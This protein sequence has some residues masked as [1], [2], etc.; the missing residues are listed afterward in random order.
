MSNC[1]EDVT[2]EN[3]LSYPIGPIPTALFHD[4][5][6]MRKAT[7]SDL[8]HQLEEEASK[9]VTL[10][11]FDSACTVVIRDGMA[12]MQGTNVKQHK[13]FGDLAS[14]Y[15]KNL[16]KHFETASTVVDVY[17]RYDVKN[18]IKGCERDRRSKSHGSPKVFEVIEGR[19]IPD[20]KKFLS[21]SQNKQA[22]IYG[23]WVNI[24]VTYFQQTPFFRKDNLWF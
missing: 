7:K 6:T 5:S 16:V 22:L 1:R 24:F 10:S 23:L 17:D 3:I 12:L 21:S 11:V 4:D 2:V 9:H 19:V 15:V 14:E 8:A 13:T 20:W 18:L